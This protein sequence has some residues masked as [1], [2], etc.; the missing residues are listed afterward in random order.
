MAHA[1][2]LKMKIPAAKDLQAILN[3]TSASAVIHRKWQKHLFC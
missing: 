1:E 2:K 3:S